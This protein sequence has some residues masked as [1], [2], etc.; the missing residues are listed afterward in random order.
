LLIGVLLMLGLVQAD[1]T[2]AGFGSPLLDQG[3]FGLGVVY[4]DYTRDV[5]DVQE[6][7]LS[8]PNDNFGYLALETRLG[9][10][11][12]RLELG[13]ELGRAHN[14]ESENPERDLITYE[15][16]YTL[17]GV[18]Y[19]RPD[20]SFFIVAGIHYRDT[21]GFDR[22][23]TLTHKVR[24]N[25]VGYGYFGRGL[26]LGSRPGR[27]YAGPHYSK[28][29]FFDY[30]ASYRP[31]RGPGVGETRDNWMLAVGFS[32]DALDW[33]EAAAE[34]RYRTSLSFGLSAIVRWSQLLGE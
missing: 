13:F 14:K 31:G 10:W 24:R 18:V 7:A 20:Q 2:R 5:Y 25:L 21:V 4:Q 29:E 19:E 23:E 26:R 6:E 30:G 1:E 33:L 32:A 22:G 34:I 27:I 12:R 17:R 3:R 28:H 15:M 16:G 8:N 11:H 9:L